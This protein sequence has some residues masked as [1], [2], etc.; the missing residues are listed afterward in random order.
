MVL[1]VPAGKAFVVEHITFQAVTAT[2]GVSVAAW[3]GTTSRP[4]ITYTG[5][6]VTGRVSTVPFTQ[7]ID[8]SDL[9]VPPNSV[10]SIFTGENAQMMVSG[11]LISDTS[12]KAL[13]PD[14]QVQRQDGRGPQMRP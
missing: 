8:V 11:Y 9:L 3:I 7:S 5:V 1:S 2:P 10:L 6:S 13:A 12:R 14:L 4:C